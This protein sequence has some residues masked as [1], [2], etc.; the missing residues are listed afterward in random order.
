MNEAWCWQGA[1]ELTLPRGYLSESTMAVTL[2]TELKKLSEHH[3]KERWETS[4]K[5]GC[6]WFEEVNIRT[7]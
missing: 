7:L 4:K 3:P 2:M 1:S 5:D 6:S